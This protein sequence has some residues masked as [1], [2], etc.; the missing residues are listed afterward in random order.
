L[1]AKVLTRIIPITIFAALF[2]KHKSI[3]NKKKPKIMKKINMSQENL[4]EVAS[5][6][7]GKLWQKGE[8]IRIYVA[9]GNN[10]QYDGSWYYDIASD[11]RWDVH[12]YLNKGYSNKNREAYVDKYL[13]QMEDDMNDAL[14]NQPEAEVKVE[15]EAV[16]PA[17]LPQ[18]GA[19]ATAGVFDE[20]VEKTK[21][22]PPVAIKKNENYNPKRTPIKSVAAL[23]DVEMGN[24][25]HGCGKGYAYVKDGMVVAFRYG[26]YAQASNEPT[27]CGIYPV[28]FSC[29]EICFEDS[30]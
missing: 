26:N 12:C 6:V 30:F 28:T 29:Y 2:D 25:Y 13:K 8:K 3:T 11:G 15:S 5:K 20:M 14:A 18:V 17:E 19:Q 23:K 22:C 24:Y 4:Q 10:Y 21:N 9:G 7:G 27:G 1:S 16:A